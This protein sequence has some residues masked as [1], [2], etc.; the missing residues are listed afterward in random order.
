MIHFSLSFLFHLWVS[1]HS[2]LLATQTA[3]EELEEAPYFLF[4][5]DSHAARSINADSL[6]YSYNLGF[7]GENCVRTYYRLRHLVEVL[8][9]KPGYV[10][11]PGGNY[12]YSK[13]FSHF[14]RN[15]FF[16]IN[17]VD[18]SEL[19]ANDHFE[20]DH[21]Q[22]YIKHTLVPYIEW[23]DLLKR[24]GEAKKKSKRSWEG[25]SK[26]SKEKSARYFV[27]TTL[28][29][30]DRNNMNDELSLLYLSMTIKLCQ[31]HE[32]VPIFIRY[33]VTQYYFNEISDF[34]GSNEKKYSKSDS[35][36]QANN[37]M[38]WDY[39]LL[40]P[41]RDD[42]F[43]DSHHMNEKGMNAFTTLIREKLDSILVYKSKHP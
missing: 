32:I 5:G 26:N 6:P 18:Y 39:R 41:D 25:L 12:R 28:F 14:K 36:M 21:F 1:K 27:R 34:L 43:F 4:M 13:V 40:F 2:K 22:L 11:L 42:Y 8:N 17:Y 24:E 20:E 19:T 23:L 30:N 31:Q 33:P 10:F 9:K 37:C 35:I 7:Y 16:Y 15:N 29:N 3:F 38:V